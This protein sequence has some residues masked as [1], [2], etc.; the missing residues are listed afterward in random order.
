VFSAHLF[1]L[2]CVL[3]RNFAHKACGCELMHPVFP[4]PSDFLEGRHLAKLGQIVLRERE[5]VPSIQ[6]S[7]QIMPQNS[8]SP[9]LR[10]HARLDRGVQY[11]RGIS[12]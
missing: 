4:A 8:V 10:C 5:R 11:S 1:V 3:S 7:G 2:V 9:R 6:L 12:V